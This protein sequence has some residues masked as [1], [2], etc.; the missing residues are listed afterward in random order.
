MSLED[1]GRRL[2]SG[3]C[4][5]E[6]SPSEHARLLQHF[7]I[8]SA[9]T[10]PL[11]P[12]LLIVGGGYSAAEPRSHID[13]FEVVSNTWTR[14]MSAMLSRRRHPTGAILNGYLYVAGGNGG[15]EAVYGN[16]RD[17]VSIERLPLAGGRWEYITPMPSYVGTGG[18]A[19][20]TALDSLLFLMTGEGAAPFFIYN[21]HRHL[22]FSAQW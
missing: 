1:V 12:G 8:Q 7:G 17:L 11:N 2:D 19:S 5:G 13:A 21:T 6:A 10:P 22:C 18:Y 14:R 20:M 9:E 16:V 3:A 15:P 4:G